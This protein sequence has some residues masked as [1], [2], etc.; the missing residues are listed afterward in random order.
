MLL[1]AKM[2]LSTTK[3]CLDTSILGLSNMSQREYHGF[4]K[5]CSN[6]EKYKAYSRVQTNV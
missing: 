3:I 4:I 5:F 1:D 2:N 6:S